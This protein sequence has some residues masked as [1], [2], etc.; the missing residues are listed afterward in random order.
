MG[1]YKTMSR[2]GKLPV[3]LSD[4]V[5]F[6]IEADNMISVKGE[7][8]SNTLRIHPNIT[9][10]KNQNEI[11][12]KR[13]SDQK[14]D[15]AMHGLYRSLINNMVVGVTEGYTTQQEFVGVGYKAESKGQML[16]M[17]LGFS[18]NFVMQIQKEI[19]IEA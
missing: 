7:K 14:Q 18:H 13:N 16:E 11:V 17:S 15:R 1:V 19:Q 8:G 5:E 4:K 9:V 10:E 12:V 6:S 2:I 3:P